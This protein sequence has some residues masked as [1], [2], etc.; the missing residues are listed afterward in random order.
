[1]TSRYG[2]DIVDEKCMI[3]NRNRF[4]QEK[5]LWGKILY[6]VVAYLSVILMALVNANFPA[7]P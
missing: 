5:G 4:T 7:K 3:G 2:T 1:M 6:I